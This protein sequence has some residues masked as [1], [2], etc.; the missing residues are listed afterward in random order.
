ML[1]ATSVGSLESS[2]LAKWS[3]QHNNDLILILI[4]LPFCKI[5]LETRVALEVTDSVLVAVATGS[6]AH[7][8]AYL[9]WKQLPPVQSPSLG[10]LRGM[11]GI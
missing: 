8:P 9:G 5:S 6:P 11:K 2:H 1:F 7:Q 3:Y 10:A 4:K